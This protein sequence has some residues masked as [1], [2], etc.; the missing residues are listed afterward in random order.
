MVT[1]LPYRSIESCIAKRAAEYKRQGLHRRDAR[2][3]YTRCEGCI[4]TRAAQTRGV[5]RHECSIDARV[6]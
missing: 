3:A 2:A 1:V 5:H 6:A 4:N